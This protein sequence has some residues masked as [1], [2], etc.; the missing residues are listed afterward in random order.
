MLSILVIKEMKNK[1][2]MRYNH[3]VTE[4]AKTKTDNPNGEDVDTVGESVG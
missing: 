2:L 4:T 1:T 3:T